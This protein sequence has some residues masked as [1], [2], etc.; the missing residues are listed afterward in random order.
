[1]FTPDEGA[2]EL[3]VGADL[4]GPQYKKKRQSTHTVF[5]TKKAERLQSNTIHID[6]NRCRSTVCWL[7]RLKGSNGTGAW[8][9]A[10]S[11]DTCQDYVHNIPNL[12]VILIQRVAVK[13]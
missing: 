10:G 3:F 13:K 6:K 8:A 5:K 4:Q 2:W 12:D 9:T 11:E 1:M 7:C